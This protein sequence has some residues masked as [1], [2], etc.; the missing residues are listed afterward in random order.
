MHSSQLS[1]IKDTY[2][3][4]GSHAF[5]FAECERIV[6]HA[7]S[8]QKYKH[9]FILDKYEYAYKYVLYSTVVHFLHIFFNFVSVSPVKGAYD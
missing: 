2:S 7:H 1:R 9:R 6:I 5:M 3:V 4:T 8:I